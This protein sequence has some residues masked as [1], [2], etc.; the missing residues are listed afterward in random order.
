[1]LCILGTLISCSTTRPEG[2]TEAEIL[3]KE[4]LELT[5]DGRY[6]LA[7]EKL[8]L[9]KSKYP[10]SFYATHAE[11]L[12]ADIHFEQ[13]NYVESAAAYI[14]FKDFHPKHERI[15]FVMWRIAESFYNQIP[16]THDR[17]LTPA[18]E[19]IKYYEE[20]N[21]KFP[22]T[23]FSK[24]AGQKIEHCRNLIESRER[25]VADFYFKTDVYDAARIRYQDILKLFKKQ[26]LLDHAMIRIVESSRLQE[27]WDDCESDFNLYKEK[28]S[29]EKSEALTNVVTK[30][31]EKR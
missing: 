29:K 6:L 23:D 3:Y 2:K 1:M 22:N 27:K 12:L 21:Q 11:L 19:A 8:N 20:L 4:A 14:L 16:P 18:H 31:R 13:E 28:I 15:N 7:T 10:Y 9:I 25:Y 5:N 26:E 17:D 24:D 30:C